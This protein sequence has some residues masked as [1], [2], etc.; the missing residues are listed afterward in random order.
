MILKSFNQEEPIELLN[1]ANAIIPNYNVS[2]KILSFDVRLNY[3]KEMCIMGRLDGNYICG[4]SFSTVDNTE[5]TQAIIDNLAKSPRTLISTEYKVLGRE[6]VWEIEKWLRM[7]FVQIQEAEHMYYFAQ[8]L[9]YS[10]ANY[11]SIASAIKTSFADL[12]KKC[13]ARLAGGSYVKVLQQYYKTLSKYK[14]SDDEAPAYYCHMKPLIAI[15]ESE[16]YLKL[17]LNPEARKLYYALAQ[18]AD[19]LHGAYMDKFR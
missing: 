15:V 10:P 5:R 7:H 19:D 13:E 6:R 12:Q 9:S 1:E 8:N 16:K 18:C 3:A 4:L 17:S 14:R 11:Q 2:E